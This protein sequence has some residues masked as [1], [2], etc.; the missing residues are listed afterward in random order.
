MTPEQAVE[1]ANKIIKTKFN[2]DYSIDNV[3]KES[4]ETVLSIIEEQD[5]IIDK[6]A[7]VICR[8]DTMNNYDTWNNDI[9]EVKQYFENKAKEK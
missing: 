3:D 7:E 2:N 4:I 9:Q 1:R 5:K 6:M 8:L